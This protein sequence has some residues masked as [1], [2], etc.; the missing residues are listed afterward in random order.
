MMELGL[1][2]RLEWWV[3]F[4]KI[5]ESYLKEA[6]PS[7]RLRIQSQWQYLRLF[8]RYNFCIILFTSN[9]DFLNHFASLHM[10]SCLYISCRLHWTAIELSFTFCHIFWKIIFTF[11]VK[12]SQK[13]CSRV[14]LFF[15]LS[16]SL[17]KWMIWGDGDTGEWNYSQVWK[18]D[19]SC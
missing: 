19:R 8:F 16:L 9:R 18:E 3:G 1:G 2:K 10:P 13:L 7:K 6:G 4:G 5:Q 14:L 17:P 12:I 15:F 11:Y